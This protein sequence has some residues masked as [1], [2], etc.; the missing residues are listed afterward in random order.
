MKKA[1]DTKTNTCLNAVLSEINTGI[2]FLDTTESVIEYNEAALH[3]LKISSLEKGKKIFDL[4]KEPEI[5]I[6]LM[7]IL[8]SDKKRNTINLE[9]KKYKYLLKIGISNVY[10][11][12]KEFIGKLITLNKSFLSKKFRKLRENFV[13]NV[14]HELK[15]PLTVIK[16]A[17]ET[18]LN[19]AMSNSEDAE[20]FVKVISKHTD[21]LSVLINDILNLSNIEQ[22]INR[23]EIPFEKF[24]VAVLLEDLISLFSETIS[25]K[26]IEVRFS[27]KDNIEMV[28]NKQLIQL[29]VSNLIDNAIK[30]NTENGNV[31]LKAEKIDN[32]IL[33]SV[34]D[35]GIGIDQAHVPRLFERFY[36]V[37]KI[38]SR[39]IGGTGLGLAIVKQIVKAHKG[40]ITVKTEL[41]KGSTFFIIL[42]AGIK[43]SA[44]KT[45][46]K[47]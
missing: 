27:C 45:G 33:I 40:M 35:S 15:T 1:K 30:Y 9:F 19:G 32:R 21:R 47:K 11:S 22:K 5:K 2:I 18:L 8:K 41:N 4:L 46:N 10:D 20:H 39:N 34:K 28:A 17:V 14:S 7:G 36:R 6:P 31:S 12:E 3:L 16:G 43:K 25:E 26:T 37:D 24:N 23:H 42:P 44:K 13:A 38:K 29:A